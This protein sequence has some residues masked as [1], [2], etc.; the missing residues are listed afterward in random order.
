MNC[1]LEHWLAC[2]QYVERQKQ[3][4]LEGHESVLSSTYK[5]RLCIQLIRS[6]EQY[7]Y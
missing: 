2:I 5:Y 7:L 6:Y 3:T 1:N 4:E